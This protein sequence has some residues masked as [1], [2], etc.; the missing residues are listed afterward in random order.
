MIGNARHRCRFLYAVNKLGIHGHICGSPS[1]YRKS[2]YSGFKTQPKP[3][4]IL[5]HATPSDPRCKYRKDKADPTSYMY[6]Y[7]TRRQRC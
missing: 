3:L 7:M 4:P 6:G 2:K 1:Q 5:T